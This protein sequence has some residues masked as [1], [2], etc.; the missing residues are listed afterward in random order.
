MVN[1]IKVGICE[2]SIPQSMRGP[3]CCKVAKDMG[4]DGLELDLG[5]AEDNFSLANPY[6]LDAYAQARDYYGVEFSGIAVNVSNFYKMTT[7]KGDPGKEIVEYAIRLGI[8]SAAKL[9][10]PL[11]HVPSFHESDITN[12]EQLKNTAEC[13][14]AACDYAA[15][16]NVIVC[17]ENHLG[18]EEQLRE[19]EMV[20]RDN[21]KIYFDSQNYQLNAGF[22]TPE[23]I[24]P[25]KDYIV[26]THVK[27]GCDIISSRLVGHGSCDVFKTLEILF[28]LGFNGW[29]VLENYY[30]KEPLYTRGSD[31][32]DLMRQDVEIV[33]KWLKENV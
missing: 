18:S 26:E 9:N 17:T 33:K 32:F 21:F 11:I 12:D 24:P 8:D 30:A 10:I 28:G 15:D 29:V 2:W 13:L 1:N 3:S 14:Q 6:V 22:Y 16:K 20:D 31:P 27:D 23:M 5:E 19:I 7:P 4:L 25:I